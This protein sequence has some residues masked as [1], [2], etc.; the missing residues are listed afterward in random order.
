[1]QTSNKALSPE[2]EERLLD[3][4]YTML[5]EF[6]TPQDMQRFLLSF[7]TP[8]ERLVFA[9]RL[10]IA[11]MLDQGKSYGDIAKT[12]NVS[13]ATISAVADNKQSDGM[14]L[15]LKKLKLESWADKTLRKLPFWSRR[16]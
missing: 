8:T 7:M 6:S 9:K 10:E 14:Q 16:G 2:D 12:L 3:Q 11:W 4:L 15:M 13:S 1:M 5:A